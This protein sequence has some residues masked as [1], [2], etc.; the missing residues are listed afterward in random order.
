MYNQLEHW[1]HGSIAFVATWVVH[2]QLLQGLSPV[3]S[4]KLING[5]FSCFA[6][7]LTGLLSKWITYMMNKYKSSSSSTTTTTITTNKQNNNQEQTEDK[8]GT[9]C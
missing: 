2:I 1:L 4:E 6:G 5:L 9:N 7:I 3:F 8:P